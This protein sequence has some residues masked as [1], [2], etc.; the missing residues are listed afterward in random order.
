MTLVEGVVSVAFAGA[1]G[2]PPAMLDS[3]E[4][5]PGVPSVSPKPYH[6][7]P[8]PDCAATCGIVVVVVGTGSLADHPVTA[9]SPVREARAPLT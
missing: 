8:V 2:S 4:P 7:Q 3:A 1:F 9:G 6:E 5:E